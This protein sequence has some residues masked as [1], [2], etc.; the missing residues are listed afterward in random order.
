[1]RVVLFYCLMSIFDAISFY[2]GFEPE[3]AVTAFGAGVFLYAFSCDT[4]YLLRG[5]DNES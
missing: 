2:V 3:G 5:K 1:M 4:Y